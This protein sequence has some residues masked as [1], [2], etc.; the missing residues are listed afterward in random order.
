MLNYWMSTLVVL[1][2]T[3]RLYKVMVR[4]PWRLSAACMCIYFCITGL[5]EILPHL[6]GMWWIN[7]NNKKKKSLFVLVP[8]VLKILIQNILFRPLTYAAVGAINFCIT[9]LLI[10]DFIYVFRLMLSCLIYN[11]FLKV[12]FSVVYVV[13]DCISQVCFRYIYTSFDVYYINR[14]NINE[15]SL[16]MLN[17]TFM[18]PCIV[19]IF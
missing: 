13:V 1:E 3:A 7:E 11:V 14:V 8:V 18:G 10:T 19:R 17:L 2:I 4:L 9:S 16:R 5:F 15:I 12:R 6:H